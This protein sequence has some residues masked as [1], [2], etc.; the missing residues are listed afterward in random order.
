M[1]YTLKVLYHYIIF[2]DKS[3]VMVRILLMLNIIKIFLKSKL[4]KMRKTRVCLI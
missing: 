1:A 2:G 3:L 4:W